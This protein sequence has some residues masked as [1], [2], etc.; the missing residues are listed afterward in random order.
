M[1]SSKSWHMKIYSIS[2]LRYIA[3]VYRVYLSVVFFFKL[4]DVCG[5]YS[6]EVSLSRLFGDFVERQENQLFI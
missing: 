2:R 6:K 3:E 5:K 1:F 4:L